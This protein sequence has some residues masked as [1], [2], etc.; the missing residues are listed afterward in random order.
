MID[1]NT[2]E[3]CLTYDP[4]TGIFQRKFH[5]QKRAIKHDQAGSVDSKGYRQ[6]RV[7]G[8]L[9]LAHRLAWLMVHGV[10]PAF[11][12]DH[13]DRNPGNN[14]I[15]NLRPCTHAENHQNVGVRSD[16]TSGVT[17]VSYL[18]LQRKWL[19]YINL[20]GKRIRL[21]LFDE[22]ASAVQARANGKTK[23]HAFGAQH[24]VNFGSK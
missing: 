14:A 17:G 10:W 4:E 11:H 5:A 15:S 1:K 20:R 22:F 3:K 24:G 13:I 7:D 23:Y 18:K 16:S 2:C 21:G 8:R 6:I 12:L 19:A 9:Y